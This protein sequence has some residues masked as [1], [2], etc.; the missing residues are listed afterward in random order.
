MD[1]L[2]KV[3]YLKRVIIVAWIALGL[4]FAIKLFGGNLFEIVCN[5][6]N[7]IAICEY[8]DNNLW[9]YCVITSIYSVVG[10]S[11]IIL[12]MSGKLKFSWWEIML[13]AIG[14]SLSSCI[15]AFNLN[16]IGLI[17]DVFNTIIAP[18]IITIKQPKRHWWVAIGNIMLV[19]F[20]L[21]SMFVKNIGIGIVDESTLIGAIF[22]I[23]VLLMSTLYYLY[24][25]LVSIKRR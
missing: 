12:A 24:S 1:K 21:V 14:N 15:K 5:N 10:S 7:F 4:C 6:T 25:N 8:C 3:K 20:Q 23:D 17:L 16:S 18:C 2:D 22:S 11:I 13:V 9:A 19:I